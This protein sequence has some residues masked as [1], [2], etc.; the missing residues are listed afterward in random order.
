MVQAMT[1][2]E[3]VR[4]ALAELMNHT[5]VPPV[6]PS[7][8]EVFAIARHPI[9]VE[10]WTWRAFGCVLG[11][12]PFI[13]APVTE[14]AI[15]AQAEKRTAARLAAR[16][17]RLATNGAPHSQSPGRN[18]VLAPGT[19]GNLGVLLRTVGAVCNPLAPLAP[20][21]ALAPGGPSVVVQRAIAGEANKGHQRR[22][23]QLS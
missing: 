7:I 1:Q 5:S 20:D 19:R 22:Q 3:T 2:S 8:R 9:R 18:I 23:A 21:R 4:P 6:Q 11:A 12:I 15:R 14:P 17:G 13:C 16:L 10:G